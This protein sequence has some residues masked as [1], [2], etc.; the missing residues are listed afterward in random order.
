MSRKVPEV[1]REFV[2][3]EVVLCAPTVDINLFIMSRYH[4]T[5]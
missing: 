2:G 1:I 3:M 4:D 5:K